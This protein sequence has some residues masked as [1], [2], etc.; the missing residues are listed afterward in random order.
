VGKAEGRRSSTI[1]VPTRVGPPA[2]S[3]CATG[4]AAP[5][6]E[7]RAP[8]PATPDPRFWWGPGFTVVRRGYDPAEVEAAFDRAAADYA[9]LVADRDELARTEVR[10]R[11]QIADLQQE[12][13]ELHAAPVDGQNLSVRL[14]HMLQLAQEEATEVRAHA[15]TAALAT[16]EQ[17]RAQARDLH[18]D[19]VTWARKT[20][21]ETDATTH[22]R[23]AEASDQATATVVEA[24]RQAAKLQR[25]AED[26]RAEAARRR[27]ASEAHAHELVATAEAEAARLEEESATERA[28]LDEASQ[29]RRAQAE[30]DFETA[31]IARRKESAAARDAI[32]GDRREA[33]EAARKAQEAAASRLA[34]THAS[35]AALEGYQREMTARFAEVRELLNRVSTAL[36]D[37]TSSSSAEAGT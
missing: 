8:Q 26:A 36:P 23:L 18:D 28:R 11:Q 22:R 2:A 32:E 6:P 14:R 12:L 17:A 31:L 9:V 29:E 37:T 1:I 24:E 15:H 7:P 3:A 30:R 27:E 33:E 5:V 19:T 4:P 13:R 35:T 34:A 16:V 20:R 10:T 25:E 21:E